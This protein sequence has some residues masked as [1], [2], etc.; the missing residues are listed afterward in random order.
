MAGVERVEEAAPGA[1]LQVDLDR[2]TDRKQVRHTVMSV[3]NFNWHVDLDGFG[4]LTERTL[5]KCLTI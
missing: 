3:L 1:V 4:L 5:K 2:G